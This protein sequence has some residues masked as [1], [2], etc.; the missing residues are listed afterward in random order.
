[1]NRRA[2]TT[3]V[4]VAVIL[5]AGVQGI[6]LARGQQKPDRMPVPKPA[7]SDIRTSLN[8]NK[9]DNGVVI[10]TGQVCNDGPGNYAYASAPLEA[11]FEVITWHPPKTATMEGDFKTYAK[12]DLGTALKAKECRSYRYQLRVEGFSRW[13]QFP[14]SATERLAWKEF[15]AKVARK[16][17]PGL[18]S[19]EDTNTGNTQVS[20]QVPYMEKI[21]K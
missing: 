16:G 2:R 11:L 4:I 12:T 13:G 14:A 17:G 3:A 18:T 7:C 9:S 10:L 20:E 5:T 6:G 1:M 15:T 21:T 19:C 8:V